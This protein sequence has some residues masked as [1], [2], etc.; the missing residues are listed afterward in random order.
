MTSLQ[1][2]N[3]ITLKLL[4]LLSNSSEMDRDE[5]INKMNEFLD[6]RESLMESIC[7]PFSEDEQRIGKQLVQLNQQVN[8]LLKLQKLEIQRDIKDLNV[9]KNST[10]KYANPYENLS[11]DGMFYDKKN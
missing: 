7:P 11:T 4:N 6:Q 1:Q 2:F 8:E 9:K 3:E 5:K 10:N